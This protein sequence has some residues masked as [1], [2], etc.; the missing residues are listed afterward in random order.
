MLYGCNSA[1]RP[2]FGRMMRTQQLNWLLA[3]QRALVSVFSVYQPPT[4]DV[5]WMLPRDVPGE[6]SLAGTTWSKRRPVGKTG[7]SI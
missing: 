1:Q 7:R 5:D 6:E 4:D 2:S 3:A